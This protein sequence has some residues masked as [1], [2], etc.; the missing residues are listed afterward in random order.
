M[1]EDRK[2]LVIILVFRVDEGNAEA[3]YK[4]DGQKDSRSVGNSL[5]P[6]PGSMVADEH[7]EETGYHDRGINQKINTGPNCGLI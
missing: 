2:Q 4:C 6:F 5:Q 7:Q 3:E 1:L